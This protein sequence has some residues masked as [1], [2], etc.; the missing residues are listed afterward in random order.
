MTFILPLTNIPQSFEITLAGV[1]YT[2]TVKWNDSFEGGWV[3]DLSDVNTN[4]PVVSNVPFI[5]GA[6]L[7]SGLDYLGIGGELWVYTDGDETAVPTLENLGVESNLY[8]V[9]PEEE[10]A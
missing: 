9:T 5:T 7:L 6:N 4:L 1:D 3:F 10:A 8:F 2:M